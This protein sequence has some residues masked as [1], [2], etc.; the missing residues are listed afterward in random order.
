MALVWLAAGVCQARYRELQAEVQAVSH[1][2]RQNTNQLCRNLKVTQ[3]QQEE[4]GAVM[5][6]PWPAAEEGRGLLACW[7]TDDG[8]AGLVWSVCGPLLQ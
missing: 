4:D 3:Q 1:A 7:L 8:G 6:Q 2:L 5:Q